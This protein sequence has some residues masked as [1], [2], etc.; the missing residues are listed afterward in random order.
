[1]KHALELA[2]FATLA[3][4]LLVPRASRADAPMREVRSFDLEASM[5][6]E[7][8]SVF[9]RHL[10][11]ADARIGFGATIQR[12]HGFGVDV[13]GTIGLQVGGTESNRFLYGAELLGAEV[14]AHAAWLRLHLGGRWGGLAEQRLQLGTSDVSH[15]YGDAYLGFGVEPYSNVWLPYFALEAHASR[16]GGVSMIGFEL[17]FGARYCGHCA[18]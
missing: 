8:T 6:W 4:S 10:D 5:G 15:Y 1:M 2:T 7:H 17:L 12:R 3:I 16:W 9:A 13:L 11:V 18:L 14:V